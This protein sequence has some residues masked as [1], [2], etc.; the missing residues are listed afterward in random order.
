MRPYL[1]QKSLK[2]EKRLEKVEKKLPEGMMGKI[3]VKTNN[4]PES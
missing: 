1:E 4:I 2:L 3:L